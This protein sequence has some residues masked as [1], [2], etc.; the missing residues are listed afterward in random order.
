MAT[1]LLVLYT[2]SNLTWYL[3]TIHLLER[4]EDTDDN[5]RDICIP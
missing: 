5:L 2:V 3:F 1:A 4:M